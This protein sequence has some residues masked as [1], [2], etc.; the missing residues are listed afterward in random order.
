MLLLMGFIVIH[1]YMVIREEIMGPTTLVS[2]MFSGYRL[3]RADAE[4]CEEDRR[5]EER[6]SC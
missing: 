3:V 2:A 4:R 1:L 6:A 5:E